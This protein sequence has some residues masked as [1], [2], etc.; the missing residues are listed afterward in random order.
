M[1]TTIQSLKRFMPGIVV[2][3][4]KIPQLSEKIQARRKEMELANKKRARVATM[5]EIV[6]DSRVQ[7]MRKIKEK[8]LLRTDD[9]VQ[10]FNEQGYKINRTQLQ[11]YLQGNVRGTDTRAWSSV[12]KEIVKNH[13][14]D[15]LDQ[16]KKLEFRLNVECKRFLNK[17]MQTIIESWYKDLGIVDG[18]RERKLAELV[19][20]DYTTIF[21]WYKENRFPKSMKYLID[22]QNVVD[23]KKLKNK[24]FF[25]VKH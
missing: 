16:F 10:L 24:S 11:A 15:L 9:L 8:F 5:G 23:A 18:S 7:Q 22:I 13:V 3:S 2:N 14:D 25:K 19:S 1:S 17:D 6:D 4:T 21:K 12:G 20:S